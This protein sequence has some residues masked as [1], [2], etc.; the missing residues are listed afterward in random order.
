M[1][2][3]AHIWEELV[4]RTAPTAVSVIISSLIISLP[5]SPFITIPLGIITL[6]IYYKQVFVPYQ[7]KFINAHI[8]TDWLATKDAGD[9]TLSDVLKMAILG[10]FPS[11]ELKQEYEKYYE[12]EQSQA[13]RDNLKKPTLI[14][15]VP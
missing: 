11:E 15:S 6:G 8:I 13:H 10:K 3:Y 14:L 12:L 9:Y 7:E 2:D 1:A 4:F 5:L